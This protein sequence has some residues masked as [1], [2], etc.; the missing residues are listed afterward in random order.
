[1]AT[2]PEA[3]TQLSRLAGETISPHA[4]PAEVQRALKARLDQLRDGILAEAAASDDVFDRESA[5]EFVT[6]RL[7]D[8]S[9]WLSA[10]QRARL[11]D[12]L[13]GK[14]DTW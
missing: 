12:G 4:T 9:K 5:L 6:A 14:I 8:L 2:D 13:R 10:S 11:L 1:M 3:L 7:D